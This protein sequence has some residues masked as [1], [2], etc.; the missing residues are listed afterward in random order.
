MRYGV[1]LRPDPMTCL[2]VTTIT[3]AIRAQYGLVSAGA[4]PPHITLVGS[5]AL[6][7]RESDL[8]QT[9]G[10]ELRGIEGGWVENQGVRRLGNAVVYDVHARHGQ[11]KE[12]LL[13]LARRVDGCVGPL[14]DPAP[15]GLAADL[16]FADRWRGHLSLASHE[17]DT[18]ADLRDEVLEFAAALD[19][20]LSAQ[21]RADTVLLYR[22]THP[23]WTGSWWQG[24]RWEHAHSWRLG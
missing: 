11:A 13:E 21:F 1:F 24:M 15:A 22:F 17:L 6:A 16:H 8:V 12:A 19:V 7:G 10:A 5:L 9:L 14:L 4:F 20:S 18:R 3:G 23:T 2:A